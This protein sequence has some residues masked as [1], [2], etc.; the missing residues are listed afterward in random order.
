MKPLSFFIAMLLA[1]VA[2][3]TDI[4]FLAMGD[5]QYGGGKPDKNDFQIAAMN[6]VTGLVWRTTNR[7][8]GQP[9]GVLIAGD[10]TQNGQ[11]GRP[12]SSDEIGQFM[13]DYGLVGEKKLKWPVY[14]GYGNHDFDPAEPAKSLTEW[15]V[16][17]PGNSTPAA[18][19]VAKRNAH[20]KGLTGTAPGKAGHYSW[21]W[22]GV[23]F[24]NVNLK[25]SDTLSAKDGQMKR[26]PRGALTFLREDLAKQVGK[27]GR[28]VVIM[29]HYG[30]DEFSTEPRWWT[31][32][33]R[34]AF[35][36]VVTNY[37]VIAIV[38]GHD[39]GTS[40]YKWNGI[41]VINAGSPFYDGDGRGHLTVVRI[42]DDLLEAADVS[43]DAVTKGAMPQWGGWDI[44]IPRKCSASL[45]TQQASG[46][47]SPATD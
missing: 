8:V 24:V 33:E 31:E 38:H 6:A 44:R 23:H 1:G 22:D 15:R 35:G 25:P 37:N 34:E 9:L 14:E 30:F 7:P 16:M 2:S 12:G 47:R 20:R 4:T 19:A 26:D 42:T 21:D 41:T 46:L 32:A 10:L 43:W 18:D 3:A 39:H 27:S 36:R 29:Q 11:D 17:Y 13:N 5:P 40:T 45:R 28:P